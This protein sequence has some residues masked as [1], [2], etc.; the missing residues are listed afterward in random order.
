MPT[1]AAPIRSNSD[2][3]R[4]LIGT[5]PQNSR[6]T[7]AEAAGGVATA[8]ASTATAA[9]ARAARPA[10]PRRGEAGKSAPTGILR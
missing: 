1:L 10:Q 6:E 5:T 8:N 4:W 3:V 9:A 7:A 2:V